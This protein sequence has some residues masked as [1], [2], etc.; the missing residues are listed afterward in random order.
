MNSLP[1][2]KG[3]EIAGNLKYANRPLEVTG[4]IRSPEFDA[5]AEGK[6]YVVEPHFQRFDVG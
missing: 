1:L 6:I 3:N 2:N 5:F 4:R